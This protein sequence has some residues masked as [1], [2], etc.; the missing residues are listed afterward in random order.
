MF[1]DSIE[2]IE[3]T[4][5]LIKK[6]QVKPDPCIAIYDLYRHLEVMRGEMSLLISF[7]Q[8]DWREYNKNTQHGSRMKKW[9]VF[10][11]QHLHEYIDSKYMLFCKILK[12]ENNSH[13][14]RGV[15]MQNFFSKRLNCHVNKYFDYPQF[16]DEMGLTLYNFKLI[17]LEQKGS[18]IRK[19]DIW[20]KS[21]IALQDDE[22]RKLFIQE[23]QNDLERLVHFI[24]IFEEVIL[25]QC[26]LEDM[27]IKKQDYTS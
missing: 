25:Q 24:V 23:M 12:L 6:K 11:N 10:V 4:L 20:S 9:V 17:K 5:E 3:F 26:T 21:N 16:D 22:A 2:I 19:D 13:E 18:M 7:M 14:Y 8:R 27:I 15:L 1:K